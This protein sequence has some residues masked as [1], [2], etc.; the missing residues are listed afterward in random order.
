MHRLPSRVVLY[1]VPCLCGVLCS[2]AWKNQNLQKFCWNAPRDGRS[3]VPELPCCSLWAFPV[4]APLLYRVLV[5]SKEVGSDLSADHHPHLDGLLDGFCC[6]P[7][8]NVL[9]W[10][11]WKSVSFLLIHPSSSQHP[12]QAMCHSRLSF[13]QRMV[14]LRSEHSFSVFLAFLP[15]MDRSR[16]AKFVRS[17]CRLSCVFAR[18]SHLHGPSFVRLFPFIAPFL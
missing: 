17:A 16:D 4:P 12:R 15:R 2:S 7:L 11:S 18:C 5:H 13:L 3:P 9:S 1:P 6:F 8:N 14:D 10:V